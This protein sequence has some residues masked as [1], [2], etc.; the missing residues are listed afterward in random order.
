MYIIVAGFAYWWDELHA[1][2]A[3][4]SALGTNER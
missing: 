1:H 2:M 3:A 4:G